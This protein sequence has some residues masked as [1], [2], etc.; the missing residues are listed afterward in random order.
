MDDTMCLYICM[1]TQ[2]MDFNKYNRCCN[3]KNVKMHRDV[4][5]RPVIVSS[6]TRSPFRHKSFN[7]EVYICAHVCCWRSINVSAVAE[8]RESLSG[9]LK[10]KWEH[11]IF[12]W[13]LNTNSPMLQTLVTME[14]C[15]F[16][17]CTIK[18]YTVFHHHE[19]ISY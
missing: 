9:S 15:P 2:V 6:D 19:Y 17:C 5:K 13:E 4:N 10:G 8:L 18:M 12:P 16:I 1:M 7:S 11:I 14:M 3:R